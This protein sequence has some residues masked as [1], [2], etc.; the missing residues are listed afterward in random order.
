MGGAARLAPVV[1][2]FGFPSPPVFLEKRRPYTWRRRSAADIAQLGERQT[3]DLKVP[4][5]IA[6]LGILCVRQGTR[7]DS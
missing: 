5:S 4:G 6:G 2:G 3:E 1:F 7:E